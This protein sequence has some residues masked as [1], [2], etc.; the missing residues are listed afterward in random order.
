MLLQA[1]HG[2]LQVGKGVASP[3]Q[4]VDSAQPRRHLD[5]LRLLDCQ[6]AHFAPAKQRFVQPGGPPS[7]RFPERATTRAGFPFEPP[8]HQPDDRRERGCRKRKLPAHGGANHAPDHYQAPVEDALDPLQQQRA[9]FLG[10][11]LH[12][13]EQLAGGVMH[14]LA[15]REPLHG[16]KHAH[17]LPGDHAVHGAVLRPDLHRL[18]HGFDHVDC[19]E[20][21]QKQPQPIGVPADQHIVDDQPHQRRRNERGGDQETLQRNQQHDQPTRRAQRRLGSHAV[22]SVCSWK[23]RW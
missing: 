5:A 11:L 14:Q 23:R 22:H 9:Q 6:H 13:F 18:E 1:S 10:V 3:A 2:M 17:P 16:A 7:L 8:P 12:P 20:G 19:N 21:A 4:S 15:P